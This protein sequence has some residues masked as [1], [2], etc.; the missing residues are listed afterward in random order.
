MDLR[1][2]IPGGHEPSIGRGRSWAR[3]LAWHLF[4]R[5]YRRAG[6]GAKLGPWNAGTIRQDRKDA[7]P[8]SSRYAQPINLA[9]LASV[10]V[11]K[12]LRYEQ[13]YAY[14]YALPMRHRIGSTMSIE[15]E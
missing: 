9:Q 3:S 13:E 1:A 14:H 5:T 10:A 12:P 7:S 6:R 8:Y 15:L 4:P 2:A 11:A